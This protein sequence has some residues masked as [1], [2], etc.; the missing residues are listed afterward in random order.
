M[1]L[2]SEIGPP[3]R[4]GDSGA[5][6]LTEDGKLAGIVFAGSP[7]FALAIPARSLFDALGVE[8]Y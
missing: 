6:V 8:L 7:E 1:T 2:R 4:G 5:P 3:I